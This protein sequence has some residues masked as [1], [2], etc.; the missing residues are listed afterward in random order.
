MSIRVSPI[1][2]IQSLV[3]GPNPPCLNRTAI[4]IT[5]GSSTSLQ[6]STSKLCLYLRNWGI[7]ETRNISKNS[8]QRGNCKFL[9]KVDPH[10]GV[11]ERC[12][13]WSTARRS[14]KMEPCCFVTFPGLVRKAD[15]SVYWE[16]FNLICILVAL[17]LP[18]AWMISTGNSFLPFGHWSSC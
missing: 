11:W 3:S 17:A 12:L 15:P 9:K 14:Q 16:V 13:G 18:M 6:Q 1:R 2:L 5:D 7:L 4:T 10:S 8:P